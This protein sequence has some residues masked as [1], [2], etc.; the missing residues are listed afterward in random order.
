MFSSVVGKEMYPT[1]PLEALKAQAVA[2]RTYALYKRQKPASPLFDM[3]NTVT[4]QVYDGMTGESQS[5]RAAVQATAGQV[6]TY[7]GRPIE[8]VFHA[9]SG[10]HT[11]NSAE[12]V[13]NCSNEEELE[14]FQPFY[15][16]SSTSRCL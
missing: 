3:G 9:S 8:A 7:Q 12:D 5:T 11:E 1:W 2:A 4:W 6:L 10:G 16:P 13:E 14:L 15:R